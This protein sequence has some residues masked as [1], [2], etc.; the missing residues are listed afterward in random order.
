MNL[1]DIA[2]YVKAFAKVLFGGAKMASRSDTACVVVGME[3]S[4]KYGRCPGSRLDSDRMAELLGKYGSVRLLQDAQA[5]TAV[6][7][8]A[9]EEAVKKDLCIL[10]YSGHGGREGDGEFLC[11]NNGPYRDRQIWDVI[12]KAKGRV[13]CIFDCCHSGHMYRDA[14]EPVVQVVEDRGFEFSFLKSA[15]MGMSDGK[16]ILVW[17][18]CPKESYSYG[19]ETGGVLTNGILDAYSDSRTYGQVWRRASGS[20][21]AQKPVVTE[22]GGGF[23]GLVFR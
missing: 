12:S 3:K 16:D 4:S 18:G 9:L 8:D 5:D 13:F 10:Y 20:A 23:S 17:S 11:L 19:G 15:V 21:A 6:F 1:F 7:R 14:G 2:R 22:I